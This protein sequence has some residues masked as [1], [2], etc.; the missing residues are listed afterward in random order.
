MSEFC[1]FVDPVPDADGSCMLKYYT[2]ADSFHKRLKPLQQV[3]ADMCAGMWADMCAGMWADMC[4]GM[5][6]GMC[7]D[8][9]QLRMIFVLRVQR[10]PIGLALVHVCTHA[11]T[12]FSMLVDTSLFSQAAQAIGVYGCV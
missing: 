12:H 10:G 2:R 4:P 6:A 11:E 1:L 9:C 7:A 5:C 3:C 8:M